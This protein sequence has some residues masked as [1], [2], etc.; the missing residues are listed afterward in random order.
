V[1]ITCLC[2]SVLAG[3]GHKWEVHGGIAGKGELRGGGCHSWP[4]DIEIP[5]KLVRAPEKK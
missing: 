5:V 1:S 3:E 2:M 4:R